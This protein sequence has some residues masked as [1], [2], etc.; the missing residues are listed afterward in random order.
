[1]QLTTALKVDVSALNVSAGDEQPS[2]PSR[3]RIQVVH[4]DI[5]KWDKNGDGKLTGRERD[6]FLKE[7]RKEKA[8]AEAAERAAKANA[9]PPKIARARPALSPEVAEQAI[10]RGMPKSIEERSA[11]TLHFV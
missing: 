1:M 10:A 11:V 4:Q 6:E 9:R 5:S 7:K 8:D 2:V 3:E